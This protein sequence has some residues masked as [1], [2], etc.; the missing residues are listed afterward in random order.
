MSYHIKFVV[1]S[2]KHI[3]KE[4]REVLSDTPFSKK[5]EPHK[6]N[7]RVNKF[8]FISKI[9]NETKYNLML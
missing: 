3:K 5:I 4:K 9:N 6:T 8:Y 1:G 7:I 2:K